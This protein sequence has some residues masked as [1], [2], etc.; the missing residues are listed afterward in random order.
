MQ[1]RAVSQG[2]SQQGSRATSVRWPCSLAPVLRQGDPGKH[3][4]GGLREP[5]SLTSSL[6][7]RRMDGCSGMALKR[8][9]TTQHVSPGC[10]S[11]SF[12]I[13]TPLPGDK[14]HGLRGQVA[15][16]AP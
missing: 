6:S 9:P 15:F 2:H 8:V 16:L 12:F 11:H 14:G 7:S 3:S 13:C 5:G 1:T 4:G 10:S